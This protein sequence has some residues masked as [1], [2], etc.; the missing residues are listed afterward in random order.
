MDFKP[1]LLHRMSLP[2]RFPEG[3]VLHLHRPLCCLELLGYQGLAQ[4]LLHAIYITSSIVSD[5]V[6]LYVGTN[7][8]TRGGISG[9]Q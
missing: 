4:F 1:F 6:L 7:S 8:T 2:P 5:M 3:G 9:L